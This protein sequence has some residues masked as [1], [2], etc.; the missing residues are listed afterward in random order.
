MNDSRLPA[1][2]RT[3]TARSGRAI[4]TLCADLGI[5]FQRQHAPSPAPHGDGQLTRPI[6]R[7]ADKTEFATAGRFSFRNSGIKTPT[8]ATD[9]N[10]QKQLFPQT[11]TRKNSYF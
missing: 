3:G 4:N 2:H 11:R 7:P 5:S 10:P 8:I 1:L 9:T 6:A